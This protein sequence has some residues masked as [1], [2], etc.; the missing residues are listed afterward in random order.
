MRPS[1][2]ISGESDVRSEA[3]WMPNGMK[4]HPKSAIIPSSD[5]CSERK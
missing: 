2:S 1:H 4:K 3:D 5:S